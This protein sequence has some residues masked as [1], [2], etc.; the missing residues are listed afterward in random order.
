MLLATAREQLRASSV[1]DIDVLN[2]RIE[3]LQD[4]TVELVKLHNQL[5]A[6][7]TVRAALQVHAG[8][9]GV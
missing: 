2:R 3:A 7:K 4:Q 6:Q 5:I 9:A 8:L 1:A